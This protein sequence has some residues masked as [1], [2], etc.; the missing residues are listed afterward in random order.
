MV[1][2]NAQALQR[3]AHEAVASVERKK[4]HMQ[5]RLTS[6]VAGVAVA[7]TLAAV[8]AFSNDA[9][10]A[11]LTVHEWGT[12]TSIADADGQGAEWRP[13]AAPSQLPCF[14]ERSGFFAKGSLPA[15]VRME[16]PV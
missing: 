9:E 7:T 3:V 2:S 12:F 15:T 16:T 6:I 11:N 8:A 14:V 10:H 13:L 4:A 5:H 1:D